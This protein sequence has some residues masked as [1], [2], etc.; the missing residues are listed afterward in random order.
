MEDE[1]DDNSPQHDEEEKQEEVTTPEHPEDGQSI[2][3]EDEGI[4]S[5]T[6]DIMSKSEEDEMS[7]Q[8]NEDR[9]VGGAVKDETGGKLVRQSIGEGSATGENDEGAPLPPTAVFTQESA[10]RVLSALSVGSNNDEREDDEPPEEI[11][12]EWKG[13][14]EEYDEPD[15]YPSE[16]DYKWVE[17]L[18]EASDE[19]GYSETSKGTDLGSLA[20]QAEASEKVVAPQ[21]PEAEGA[22]QAVSEEGVSV[23]DEAAA[24]GKDA[25]AEETFEVATVEPEQEPE[26][27]PPKKRYKKIL[28]KKLVERPP[29]I[30]YE[31][32]YERVADNTNDP[33]YF[34]HAPVTL[35]HSFG[36]DA[37]RM[38]NL[39]VL[40]EQTLVFMSGFVLTFLDHTT[41]HKTYLKCLGGSCFGALAVHPSKILFAAAEKGKNPVI[42]IWSWPKLQLF[43]KLREGTNKVY[44]SVNFSPDGRLLASQGGEPDY[45]ITVWNWL[46]E[47]PILRVKSHSQDVYR[48][49]FS[50]ELAG[51]LTTSG[52]CHIKFWKMADTFTG[53][54]LKGDIG[55]FGRTELSDIE[56]YI[57]MPDGKVLSGSEWGNLLVWEN[58]L[59]IAELCSRVDVPC[60]DGIVRQV[61]LTDGEFY[62]TGQ[63]GWVKTWNYDAVDTAEI[64]TSEE[65]IKVPIKVMAQV[66][67]ADGADIWS[68]VPNIPD[69]STSSIFWFAQDGAGSIW[70]VDLSF[71]NTAKEPMLISTAHGGPVVGCQI[72]NDNCLF[73]TLGKDGQVRVY[74][75]LS[76]ELVARRHF[77]SAGSCF[78]WPST[79]ID[80]QFNKMIAGFSDGT[81]RVMQL[82]GVPTKDLPLSIILLSAMKPHARKITSMALDKNAEHFVTGSEDG[83]VFFFDVKQ[84]FLPMVFVAMPDYRGVSFLKWN[85][86]PQE[87]KTVFAVLDGGFIQEIGVP[88]KKHIHNE[89]SYHYM[90]SA[91]L[92]SYYFK[93]IKSQLRHNEELER[94]RL[95]EEARQAAQEEENR[96][97]ITEGMETQSEQDLRLLQEAEEFERLKL[98]EKPK[99]KW[100]PYYPP[101]PSPILCLMP[102]VRENEMFLSMGKYDSGYLYHVKMNS[103]VKAEPQPQ[104]P[105]GAIPVEDSD[106]VPITAF[107]TSVDGDQFVFGFADGRI[108]IQ[109]CIYPFDL[110]NM[111]PY[112]TE[113]V[114]DC[115]KGSITSIALDMKGVFMI[116]CANDGNT[117]LHSFLHPDMLDRYLENLYF[118]EVPYVTQPTT[119]QDII[120]PDAYTLEKYKNIEKE[121]ALLAAAKRSKAARKEE[122]VRLRLWYCDILRQNSEL[123][124]DSRLTHTELSI[125]SDNSVRREEELKG[126]LKNL[127]VEMAWETE[128]CNIA[129][130]K[131]KSA[132]KD[133]LHNELFKLKSFNSNLSVCSFRLPKMPPFFE[134]AK[135]RIEHQRTPHA[136]E[137]DIIEDDLSSH[138][139]SV[140]THEP[141]PRKVSGMDRF[142]YQR[143]VRLWER[144]QRKIQRSQVW[145]DFLATEPKGKEL[146][147]EDKAI[148]KAMTNMGDMKLK[149]A[150]DYKVPEDK[151]LT[152][153]R[154]RK[155]CVFLEEIIFNLK[156]EFNQKL[157]KLRHQKIA[158]INRMKE[159]VRVIEEKQKLLPAGEQLQIPEIEEMTIEENPYSYM[160]YTVEDIKIYKRQME[161]K[162]KA[163]ASQ[164][165][166]KAAKKPEVPAK[167][168]LMGNQNLYRKVSSG[169]NKVESVDQEPQ[170]KKE[171]FDLGNHVEDIVSEPSPLERQMAKVNLTN[172][173]FY[174]QYYTKLIDE[175]KKAF[176]V[177]LKLLR[178]RKLKLDYLL[179]IADERMVLLIDEFILAQ[180][181]E[182]MEASIELKILDAN[183]EKKDCSTQ[184]KTLQKKLELVKKDMEGYVKQRQVLLS[185]VM[186]IATRAPAFEKYLIRVFNK[187]LGKQKRKS[188]VNS[189]V[190]NPESDEDSESSSDMDIEEEDD[191]DDGL[192]VDLP[193]SELNKEIYEQVLEVRDKRYV[194]DEYEAATREVYDDV[195]NGM[196]A[197][198]AKIRDA[199]KNLETGRRDLD[200]FIKEKQEKQND[201]DCTVS[202]KLHQ[203]FLMDEDMRDALCTDNDTIEQLRNR[204]P[205][206]RKETVIQKK[207][208]KDIKKQHY[209]LQREKNKFLDR[210]EEM[211]AKCDTEM[212]KKFGTVRAIEE[213]EYFSKDPEILTLQHEQEMIEKQHAYDLHHYGIEQRMCVTDRVDVTR[214]HAERMY[215]KADMMYQVNDM[216]KQMDEQ[217]R[218]LPS[219][220]EDITTQ[221]E[222]AFLKTVVEDQRQVLNAL[223]REIGRMTSRLKPL[224]PIHHQNK[225]Q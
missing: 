98:E 203:I 74:N 62:T 149:M 65:S 201:L 169:S 222:I 195:N 81:L 140:M 136:V 199:D 53:L 96:K 30:H 194:I 83:T 24:E 75:Y 182:A 34:I 6:R 122:I 42:G 88:E 143:Q 22:T 47:T 35:I 211:K 209:T 216:T 26:P 210:L 66:Q 31:P 104:E 213:L 220:Y 3:E 43:R 32:R 130:S 9:G 202:I 174:Q 112:W 69:P 105:I 192:D 44:A 33:G 59:I 36:Y 171:S 193:P 117:F 137:S 25:D 178:H 16:K 108:R 99:P 180:R 187:K 190:S 93:S 61:L 40:D 84:N 162:M 217:M 151:K 223:K 135:D 90:E 205:E 8:S 158:H 1:N 15:I 78:L 55:R 125:T 128:K 175:E 27:E 21:V 127:E 189:E 39:H 129:L 5:S 20:A 219:E 92:K 141:R 164:I 49:T 94:E 138:V 134:A 7:G 124:E 71:L 183:K 110:D 51:R 198:K 132:Y 214:R 142:V 89:T 17:E 179:K 111:G 154:A 155:K 163:A 185:E 13:E 121:M 72:S 224:P 58:G 120:D 102:G 80:G 173:R 218:H 207:K 160:Y 144:K 157:I 87:K 12:Y 184:F 113:G 170:E 86:L 215:G 176:D 37:Q 106:D 4:R 14:L 114:H 38:A 45:L 133:T 188:V 63:D 109:K 2:P 19:E 82:S 168:R 50:K 56:G 146:R 221:K 76:R 139:S 100:E 91:L 172:A 41:L 197:L 107:A 103:K 46:A 18:V 23:T 11:L 116:T 119:V 200:A 10:T 48:V 131:M 57:E 28:V 101:E 95:A 161:E 85:Y 118:H 165:S 156:N 225:D 186:Q 204:I 152:E 159:Y 212:I 206:L 60:H 97:K 70:K 67:V 166:A 153:H 191:D 79:L 147:E 115:V 196:N 167:R 145:K 177:K 73:A 181:S 64:N 126:A 150:P 29:K 52:L 208:G 77:T 68:I 148:E 54:K 123:P